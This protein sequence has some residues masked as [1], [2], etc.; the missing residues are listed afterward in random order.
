MSLKAQKKNL[1]TTGMQKRIIQ[2]S[3]SN[4]NMFV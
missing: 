4:L 1:N 2:K 3:Q